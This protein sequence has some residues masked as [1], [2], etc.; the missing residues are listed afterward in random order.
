MRCPQIHRWLPK[1]GH[2]TRV[3]DHRTYFRC[4]HN[5]QGDGDPERP[6]AS[7]E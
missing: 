5:W 3:G 4:G 6:S 7:G 2:V 1:P